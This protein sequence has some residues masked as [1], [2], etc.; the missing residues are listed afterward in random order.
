MLFTMSPRIAARSFALIAALAAGCSSGP[1]P[2]PVPAPTPTRT[3]PSTTVSSTT[4]PPVNVAA[5]T[6]DLFDRTN[7][8][9]RTAGMTGYA[10]SV[11]LMQAAQLQADQMVKA[12]RMSHELAGQPYP[13]LKAR[14]A[15]VNYQARVVG[16]N[17]AEG[18]RTAPDVVT[19]WMDSS[20][21]RAN[22]LSREFTE[23]GT[24]VAVARN[25][26]LYFVAVFGRPGPAP[27]T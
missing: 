12:G 8:A 9:R 11:N 13:T 3:S 1:A 23:L 24:G 27:S 21:H 15:A 6:E 14:L 16:E 4:L 7:G 19:T 25:G 20:T 22:L 17:I 5:L 10:R 26:R 18:Q 2:A